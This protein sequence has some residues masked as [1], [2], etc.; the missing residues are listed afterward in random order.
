MRTRRTGVTTTDKKAESCKR[1][2]GISSLLQWELRTTYE[3]PI[4]RN[5]QTIPMAHNEYVQWRANTK[6]AVR[7]I[8]N[9]KGG[10]A[11]DD[12]ERAEVVS[13]DI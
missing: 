4:D 1:D 9:E 3:H 2:D 6:R 7:G 13:K 10:P 11:V 12:I 8:K 5:A